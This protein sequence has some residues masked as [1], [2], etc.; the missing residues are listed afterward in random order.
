MI[1][2]SGKHEIG[3]FR[4]SARYSESLKF[5]IDDIWLFAQYRYLSVPGSDG[6]DVKELYSHTK[7][8]KKIGKF[9]KKVNWLKLHAK[10][11]SE[12]GKTGKDII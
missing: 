9:G 3:L 6:R 7:L 4:I 1:F 10:V 8:S 11:R 2:I 5:E 12:L